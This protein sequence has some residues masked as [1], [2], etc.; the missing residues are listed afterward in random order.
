MAMKPPPAGPAGPRGTGEEY[1]RQCR[2][3]NK[4]L[5]E[6]GFGVVWQGQNIMTAQYVAI[7]DMKA[8][9]ESLVRESVREYEFL[10]ELR[11]PNVV[12]VYAYVYD[13]D[14]KMAS[15]FMEYMSQGSLSNVIKT[16]YP[17]GMPLAL[18]SKYTGDVLKGLNC[19][20]QRGL[21]HRD[22]KP[23]NML[24]ATTGALK[25]ADFG[26]C[27]KR[28]DQTGSHVAGTIRYMS[29]DALR[30]R[31]N[32]DTDIWAVG[33]SILEMAT[34]NPPYYRTKLSGPQLTYAILHGTVRPETPQSTR[35]P[36]FQEFAAL[37]LG[38]SDRDGAAAAFV[39]AA[40]AAAPADDGHRSHSRSHSGSHS[41]GQMTCDALLRHPFLNITSFSR[42]N[43]TQAPSISE[44][45]QSTLYS[46]RDDRSSPP[47][48]HPPHPHQGA[49]RVPLPSV[50]G[51]GGGGGGGNPVSPQRG[52][53]NNNSPLQVHLEIPK[54]STHNQ[55]PQP[56][57]ATSLKQT[58]RKFMS[59]SG[60]PPEQDATQASVEGLSDF[61]N[62]VN[63]PENDNIQQVDAPEDV[64]VDLVRTGC[65]EVTHE[66]L[67]QLAEAPEDNYKVRG[68]ELKGL[69]F[70]RALLSS[71]LRY[72]AVLFCPDCHTMEPAYSSK[73][74]YFA[75]QEC[76]SLL[77]DAHSLLKPAS[78]KK[79]LNG[80]L[81]VIEL[82]REGVAFVRKAHLYCR[83][84]RKK[85]D[86]GNCDLHTSDQMIDGDASE[87]EEEFEEGFAQALMFQCQASSVLLRPGSPY[88]EDTVA[89]LDGYRFF[90]EDENR[91]NV[92]SKCFVLLNRLSGQ[93]ACRVRGLADEMYAYTRSLDKTTTRGST[94]SPTGAKQPQ[95]PS[96][97]PAPSSESQPPRSHLPLYAGIEHLLQFLLLI[98]AEPPKGA[99]S[100]SGERPD[101]EGLYHGFSCGAGLS[102]FVTDA[103]V[104]PHTPWE[105]KE[106]AFEAILTAYQVRGG[107]RPLPPSAAQHAEAYVFPLIAS[108]SDPR[109]RESLREIWHY[110]PFRGAFDWSSGAGYRVGPWR[111]HTAFLE[112]V[113]RTAQ[114]EGF[115]A[116]M[117]SSFLSESMTPQV[118]D[119]GGDALFRGQAEMSWAD[120]FHRVS[121]FPPHN[122]DGGRFQAAYG[123]AFPLVRY[124]MQCED[125]LGTGV[126]NKPLDAVGRRRDFDAFQQYF[127]VATMMQDLEW[128]DRRGFF[129]LGAD[130]Q[131]AASFLSGQPRG[132]FIFRPSK[133]ERGSLV[134]T[135]V[136]EGRDGGTKVIHKITQYVPEVGH[137]VIDAIPLTSLKA[138]RPIRGL[139]DLT[140]WIID[141]SPVYFRGGGGVTVL[142]R[143][144]TVSD[145]V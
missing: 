97:S 144:S 7:K 141:L 103:D 120:F 104:A 43:S 61:V 131:K 116:W 137:L 88:D 36:E 16:V 122:G 72:V 29:Q 35:F 53:N 51:G 126:L 58:L 67:A 87:D 94:A 10:T 19:A 143:D 142:N 44:N 13:A 105:V 60:T 40:A 71:C 129:L 24:V 113:Q 125:V 76:L 111:E 3:F 25:L 37:C 65:A 75:A 55:S 14:K 89:A 107:A 15:I 140:D 69:V 124:L 56:F 108:D 110:M 32:E 102:S 66:L 95:Q 115:A 49:R 31:Y 48:S 118:Q 21:I 2:R 121:L 101:L 59:G 90:R 68:D 17:K 138:D 92:F 34:G 27:K 98:A 78:E 132:C 77:T 135:A 119:V 96:L 23:A 134:L 50:G 6:G 38:S 70:Q 5:G 74:V 42:A 54:E 112:S 4:K 20:H 84:L 28:R 100:A 145:P 114:S 127:P 86:P 22:I 11:H 133:R 85:L 46:L 130:T 57:E 73:S 63:S 33:C 8:D 30:G 109:S 81:F 52:S 83:A 26:L 106:K 128:M 82:L 39:A 1:A 123:K 64:L 79:N 41:G 12:D 45:T 18:V 47:P 99:G 80:L 139:R 62:W 9:A 93:G 91:C 117:S 136:V